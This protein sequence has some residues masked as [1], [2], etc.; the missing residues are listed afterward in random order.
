VG[1]GRGWH[2]ARGGKREEGTR[3]GYDLAVEKMR[4][5]ERNNGV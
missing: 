3:E 4:N 2:E 1:T 5:G